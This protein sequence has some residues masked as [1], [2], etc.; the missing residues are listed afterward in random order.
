MQGQGA[1]GR[2]GDLFIQGRSNNNSSLNRG[3]GITANH[4]T[5][6]TG[7]NKI[8]TLNISGGYTDINNSSGICELWMNL[9]VYNDC[10]S[11]GRRFVSP[12]KY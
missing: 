8:R 6:L 2:L 3:G 12:E 1:S 11:V 4:Q 7:H 9:W 10:K 5:K